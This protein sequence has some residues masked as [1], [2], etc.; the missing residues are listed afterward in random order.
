MNS[1][2]GTIKGIIKGTF[3]GNSKKENIKRNIKKNLFIENSKEMNLSKLL[4]SLMQ[5]NNP[6]AKQPNFQN[7]SKEFDYIL[8]IDK[9]NIEEVERVIKWCQHDSFWKS[10]ILSPKKLREKY[11]QLYLKMIEENNKNQSAK[12]NF[13]SVSNDRDKYYR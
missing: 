7:W 13:L 11:D 5:I 6:K 12:Y 4:F 3:E 9:K 2:E 8:R 10:N 1:S